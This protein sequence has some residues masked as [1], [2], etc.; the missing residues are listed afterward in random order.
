MFLFCARSCCLYTLLPYQL[1]YFQ[2]DSPREAVPDAPAVYFVRPTESNIKRI[3]EDCAKQVCLL[4]SLHCTES[5]DNEIIVAAISNS[6]PEL[7]DQNRS[8]FNGKARARAGEHKLRVNGI[9]D[10]RPI[11]RRDCPGTC[12]FYVE[13]KGFIHAI[14]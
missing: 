14:Q 4:T 11:L 10:L 6:I 12:T 7:S 8:S 13:H 1:A 2:I 3:A 5:C 9:Q